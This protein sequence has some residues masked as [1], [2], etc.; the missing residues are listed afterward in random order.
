[1]PRATAVRPDFKIRQEVF[2]PGRERPPR[3]CAPVTVGSNLIRYVVVNIGVSATCG[4]LNFAGADSHSR[5]FGRSSSFPRRTRRRP[6]P[7]CDSPCRRNGK[8]Q[9]HDAAS[10][11][12]RNPAW[13]SGRRARRRPA[14]RGESRRCLRG[15]MHP[16]GR[17]CSPVA[18]ARQAS[19]SRLAGHGRF[20]VR[21]CASV[22]RR[23]RRSRCGA[24]FRRGLPGAGGGDRRRHRC[25]R[26]RAAGRDHRGPARPP[27]GVGRDHRR[28]RAVPPGPARGGALSGDGPT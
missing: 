18:H 25:V 20:M 19:S 7:A 15:A 5:S 13:L 6:S 4:S 9:T 26:R 21:E 3:V 22:R 17:R 1:M 14:A 24:G 27:R 10:P 16:A 8:E 11:A 28:R 2:M 12:A 23:P